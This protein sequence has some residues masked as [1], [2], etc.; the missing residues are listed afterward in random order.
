MQREIESVEAFIKKFS[1]EMQTIEDPSDQ[2]ILLALINGIRT[3]EPLMA[4]LARGST[5]GTLWQFISRVEGYI[6]QEEVNKALEKT[7]KPRSQSSEV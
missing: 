5:M 4:E 3:K 7:D 2:I 6:Y 1:Q